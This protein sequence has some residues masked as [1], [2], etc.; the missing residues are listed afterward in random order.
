MQIIYFG[1]NLWF[2]MF[3]EIYVY[4]IIYVIIFNDR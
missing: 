2:K 1:M 3:D 4:G